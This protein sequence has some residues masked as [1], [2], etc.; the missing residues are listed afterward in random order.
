MADRDARGGDLG[1]TAAAEPGSSRT[2]T[3]RHFQFG[4]GV[5]GV[6][7]KAGSKCRVKISRQDELELFSSAAGRCQRPECLRYVFEAAGARRVSVGEM[8]HI[9]AASGDGPRGASTLSA[10]ERAALPNLLLLC[11]NCHTAADK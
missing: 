11:A 1:S 3:D 2:G 9:I 7:A 6:A 8:A 4:K 10:G 5:I